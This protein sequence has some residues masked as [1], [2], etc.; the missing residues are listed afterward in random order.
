VSASDRSQLL[1]FVVGYVNAVLKAGFSAHSPFNMKTL[2]SSAPFLGLHSKVYHLAD[3]IF[4]GKKE[5]A[6]TLQE[7][8]FS[9]PSWRPAGLPFPLQC[10]QCKFIDCWKKEPIVEDAFSLQLVCGQCGTHHLCRTNTGGHKCV[11]VVDV[12]GAVK[13]E[14]WVVNRDV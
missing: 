3:P 11:K 1:P 5:P 10:P 12:D 9:S 14:W 13:G 4:P 8:L 7:F 6:W 2:L